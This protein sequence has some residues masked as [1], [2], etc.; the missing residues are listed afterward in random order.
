MRIKPAKIEIV[1]ENPFL[2]DLLERKESAEVL[3]ELIASIEEPFVFCIDAA[4]GEGKTTFLLMWK[5]HLENQGFSTL[6]YNAW[7]NDFTNDALV[8]LIGELEAGVE[9]LKLEKGT[10][11]K[12]KL[13]LNKMKKIGAGLLKKA[14]PATVK[15]ATAGVVDINEIA[16]ETLTNLSESFAKDQI[17]EYEKSKRSLKNFKL[18]LFKFA[19]EVSASTDPKKPLIIIIDE[20]DRCRPT[21]AIEILEKAKHFFD[22]SNIVFVIAVDKSQIGHSIRS[23]YGIG[24]DVNGYLKRFIDMEF[25][26]P[27]P[28]KGVFAKA[29]FHRFGLKEYFDK[30][31]GTESRYEYGHLQET[32][33]N[34]FH[35]LNLS[36]REQEQ[37]FSQLTI[38]IRTTPSNY[39][40]YPFLLGT[41][42]TLKIKNPK[43]YKN[44]ITG[45]ITGLEII[46]EIKKL[47]GGAEFLDGS[48]YGAVLEGYFVACRSGRRDESELISFYQSIEN[49]VNATEKEKE[50]AKIILK[51]FTS[52]WEMQDAFGCLDYILQKIEVSSQFSS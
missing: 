29:L 42:I 45:K 39:K 10:K 1:Q 47:P 21:F 2:R 7:E 27:P 48:N 5:Q 9:E 22:V 52:S 16:D 40:L 8:S 44:F 6:Y 36:L 43:L 50:R 25:L 49:D 13:H 41:L 17:D 46:E 24:M 28:K 20:L 23:V 11:T 35:I 34:L 51:L 32:I 31:A 18:E 4:W 14:I 15:I 12:A 33:Q 3:T 38:A 26:L 19:A 37:C 30:R